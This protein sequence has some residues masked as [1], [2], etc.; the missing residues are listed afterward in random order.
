MSLLLD[1]T[2]L[3]ESAAYR[4][5]YVGTSLTAIGN[6]L[7]ATTISLQVYALTG[8]S[9]EVG[10]VGLF[11]LLP[12]LVTGLWGGAI[13]DAYDRRTV[14]IIGSSVMWVSAALNLLQAL[15]GNTHTWVLFL[16]VALNTA[17]FGVVSPARMA[18]YPRILAPRLLPAANALTSLAMSAS[19]LVGPVFAGFLVA[20]F[21]YPVTY[22]IDTAMFVFAMWGLASLPA[23]P[24]EIAHAGR[25]PGLRSVA[26]G[27]TYLAG[28]PNLRMT[29]LTDFCAM[30]LANPMALFPAVAIAALGGGPDVVGILLAGTAAGSLLMSTFSGRLPTVRWQGRAVVSSVTGWGLAVFG[31]G[32]AVL[33]AQ[34]GI[35]SAGAGTI[36]AFV[37]LAAAGAFDT[38]SMVFRNTIMQTAADDRMRGR[39]Q[40][41]FIVVVAGGPRL[42]QFLLGALGSVIGEWAA[43][44]IGGVACVVCVQVLARMQGGFLRYDASN[45]EP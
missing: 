8:S 16:L 44:V 37:A 23:I 21:G 19:I 42:G 28:R 33:A 29:F 20:W 27:F 35:L 31:F 32:F 25:V 3:R 13:T 15:L 24:P 22:A 7:A 4:R 38:V 10:L 18:I 41:I 5:L 11:G 43:A 6:V 12:L 30:I 39:L 17:G 36:L 1:I 40:G 2:P 45:P 14:A 26:D 9:F 34:S